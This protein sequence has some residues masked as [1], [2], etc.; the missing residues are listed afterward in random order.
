M[1]GTLITVGLGEM[2]T[3]GGSDCD[4]YKSPHKAQV[5]LKDLKDGIWSP[6]ET[7]TIVNDS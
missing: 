5:E 4:K 7:S 6:K 3:K 1:K 2:T